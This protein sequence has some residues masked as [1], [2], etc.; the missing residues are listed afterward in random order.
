MWNWKLKHCTYVKPKPQKGE[1]TQNAREEWVM[2]EPRHKRT[3]DSTCD[4]TEQPRFGSRCHCDCTSNCRYALSLRLLWALVQSDDKRKWVKWTEGQWGTTVFTNKK[5]R[6]CW[7]V[8][9][10]GSRTKK[11]GQ[12]NAPCVPPYSCREA[13]DA[14]MC[15]R[16]FISNNALNFE[17]TSSTNECVKYCVLW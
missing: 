8:G 9:G 6:G 10:L 16:G 13:A 12:P 15:K 14:V 5:E 1:C 17:K 3:N 4:K 11:K 2:C 7:A